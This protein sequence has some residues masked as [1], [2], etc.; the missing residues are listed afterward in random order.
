[1][2]PKFWWRLF[3]KGMKWLT[4][5]YRSSFCYLRIWISVALFLVLSIFF[6]S[7]FSSFWSIEIRL[8]II[9]ASLSTLFGLVKDTS[10]LS[11]LFHV[12]QLLI[13]SGVD[14]SAQLQGTLGLCH[15]SLVLSLTR[16]MK[17]WLRICLANIWE[18][19]AHFNLISIKASR[20]ISAMINTISEKFHC[21]RICFFVCVIC[22]ASSTPISGTS[23]KVWSKTMVGCEVGIN[24]S[25]LI[26]LCPSEGYI[27]LTETI[28]NASTD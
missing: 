5:W 16:W 13:T 25:L 10:L 11:I 3:R 2:K 21:L 22:F 15:T 27:Y 4:S 26:Y 8:A 12:H 7:L 1:M 17:V 18:G 9:S 14:T 23:V 28:L 19:F 6:W 24:A 20:D